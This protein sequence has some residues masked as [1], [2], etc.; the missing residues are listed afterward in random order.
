MLWGGTE[1][2][3]ESG[4][5]KREGETHATGDLASEEVR[6]VWGSAMEG[7][8]LLLRALDGR[9]AAV[10]TGVAELLAAAMGGYE[11]TEG[12]STT[13]VWGRAAG[14]AATAVLIVCCGLEG[15]A[16]RERAGGGNRVE[17]EVVEVQRGRGLTGPRWDGTGREA[18][19]LFFFQLLQGRAGKL[20]AWR[21]ANCLW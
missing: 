2:S 1:M 13:E 17:V 7:G 18:A 15:E 5:T 9:A 12:R 10:L 3:N 16:A 19:A 6:R 21:R 11:R 4:C 20:R 14:A 8:L